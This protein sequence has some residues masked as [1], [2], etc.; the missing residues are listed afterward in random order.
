M[1]F[2]QK[3][4]DGCVEKKTLDEK[5]AAKVWDTL[6]GFGSYGFNR[7]HAVEYSVITYWDMWLKVYYPAEFMACSLSYGSDDKKEEY[8]KEA[9]RLGL[10]IFLPTVGKSLPK[11]WETE[12]AKLYAPFL[13]MKG[14]GEKNAKLIQNFEVLPQ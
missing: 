2:K 6:A 10:E 14:V 8:V 13:E 7:S 3:F 5:V 11:K 9:R 12:G 1:K 4:V